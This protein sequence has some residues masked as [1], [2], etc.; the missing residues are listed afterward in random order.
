MLTSNRAQHVTGK[1]L[2]L[3]SFLQLAVKLLLICPKWARYPLQAAAAPAQARE[4]R[5]GKVKTFLVLGAGSS[6]QESQGNRYAMSLPC[7]NV[8][9]LVFP[10]TR[11][12]EKYSSRVF[13]ERDPQRRKANTNLVV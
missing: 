1:P 8:P 11:Q 3:L 10:E 9:S 7:W 13:G 2:A 5:E 4:D 6:Q 12:D